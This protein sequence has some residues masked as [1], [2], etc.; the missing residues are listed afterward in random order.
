MAEEANNQVSLI[1]PTESNVQEKYN[2]TNLKKEEITGVGSNVIKKYSSLN[3]NGAYVQLYLIIY[4]ILI[5][6]RRL[7]FKLLKK[8]KERRNKRQKPEGRWKL[9]IMAL[10]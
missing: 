7:C 1:N 2:K 4:T 8:T 9:D 3:K 5:K 6:E 10:S